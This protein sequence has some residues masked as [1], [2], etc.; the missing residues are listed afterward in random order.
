MA[1]RFIANLRADN[2][3]LRAEN[4]RP[5]LSGNMK[6]NSRKVIEAV[7]QPG[8]PSAAE[9]LLRA[10]GEVSR[11]AEAVAAVIGTGPEAK[12]RFLSVVAH[13]INKVFGT[14]RD[15]GSFWD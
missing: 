15:T 1:A 3:R 11:A 12:R 8:K 10:S 4:M 6:Q 7:A 2:A 5:L 9:A 13:E 14:E